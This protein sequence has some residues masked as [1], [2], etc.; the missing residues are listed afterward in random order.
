MRPELVSYS[1][2]HS[3]LVNHVFSMARPCPPQIFLSIGDTIAANI[4]AYSFHG[5]M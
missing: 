2:L 1:K 3:L 5:D 4:P